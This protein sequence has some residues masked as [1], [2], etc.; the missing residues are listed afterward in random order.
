MLSL[1]DDNCNLYNILMRVIF[2]TSIGMSS[3]IGVKMCSIEVKGIIF[4][5]VSQFQSVVENHPPILILTIMGFN[6]ICKL[7]GPLYYNNI[8]IVLKIEGNYS[9]Q[10][11]QIPVSF[12]HL[13]I[14][15]QV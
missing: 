7:V 11:K 6:S 12:Q 10:P 15:E 2:A 4:W 8:G 1:T 14:L 5:F 3:D 13:H 9:W